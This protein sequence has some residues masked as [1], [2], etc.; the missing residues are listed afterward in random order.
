MELS[1]V[2]VT[3]SRLAQFKCVKSR[4]M[5]VEKCS[6]QYVICCKVYTCCYI[7]KMGL[8]EEDEYMQDMKVT[9]SITNRH[10]LLPRK[11]ILFVTD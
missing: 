2:T 6:M 1:T 4:L 5:Q 8:G 7:S 10:G 11:T 9:R 3:T